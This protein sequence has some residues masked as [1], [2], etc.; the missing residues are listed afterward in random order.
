M[1]DVTRPAVRKPPDP[2]GHQAKLRARKPPGWRAKP[3]VPTSSTRFQAVPFSKSTPTRGPPLSAVPFNDSTPTRTPVP[4]AA[5]PSTACQSPEVNPNHHDNSQSGASLIP[6]PSE[7]VRSVM[8]GAMRLTGLV[9][10][11]MVKVT[12]AASATTSVVTRTCCAEN[13]K[14]ESSHHTATFSTARQTESYQ[15]A[16]PTDDH[17]EA[18]P[19]PLG[20]ASMAAIPSDNSAKTGPNAPLTRKT[21]ALPVRK[22]APVPQKSE[23]EPSTEASPVERQDSQPDQE[24][25]QTYSVANLRKLF[26]ETYSV[27]K[28][29]ESP[30]FSGTYK[31]PSQGKDLGSTFVVR[32]ENAEEVGALPFESTDT[33]RLENAEE[34]CAQPF[35]KDFNKGRK[36][37]L[38][39]IPTESHEEEEEAEGQSQGATNAPQPPSLTDAMKSVVVK[40]ILHEGYSLDL[41][42]HAVWR[43]LHS[44]GGV[45][46]RPELLQAVKDLEQEYTAA[47]KKLGD[48]DFLK[49]KDEINLALAM[50]RRE[51]KVVLSQGHDLETVRHVV[52]R[53]LQEGKGHFK[54]AP[55]LLQAVSD[56][57]REYEQASKKLAD[58]EKTF[59]EKTVAYKDGGGKTVDA[60][61]AER[62]HRSNSVADA[63]ANPVVE[64]VLSAGYS[65][66]LVQHAVWR[67][68]ETHG[69]NFPSVAELL[70]ALKDL[71]DEYA[72]AKEKLGNDE[73]PSIPPAVTTTTDTPPE[74]ENVPSTEDIP[75]SPTTDNGLAQTTDDR[76]KVTTDDNVESELE[77]YREEH[78]CKV[79][80]DARI[81]VV[82][83]PCGHYACCGHCADGMVECPMC[84]RGVDS[85]VKVFFS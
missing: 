37:C 72:R 25:G 14:T 83:V 11:T 8:T 78:T 65:R 23:K 69:E 17:V 59:D 31:V 60:T 75:P 62:V 16:I 36:L 71:E 4:P 9:R 77:R 53:R 64:N 40:D 57:K 51:V 10:E 46:S 33:V 24:L 13:T 19:P 68:L 32:T 85:T 67:R 42:R 56:L 6:S 49:E 18:G 2:P 70:Q 47:E 22:A 76:C 44:A 39:A 28:P 82:F 26:G 84:R 21:K 50:E 43:R 20:K 41:V 12:H 35:D 63:M 38:M 66:D 45:A 74:P 79:C 27:D 3:P 5:L 48:K 54:S 58:A 34:V 1:T 29:G 15:M 52:W 55:E 81:E 61:S 73:L 30:D 80:F 7:A